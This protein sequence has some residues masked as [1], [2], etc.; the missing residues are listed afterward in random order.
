M[1]LRPELTPSLARLLLQK[2]GG[3]ALP[4]KWWAIGQCWRYERATRGRRREHYQW[5]MDVVGVAGVEAE[6]ELLGALVALFKRVGLTAADV[7]LKV[8]SRCAAEQCGCGCWLVPGL[9]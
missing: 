7:G 8:S 1:S 5:N 9:W 2:K 4:A 6:A 3:L